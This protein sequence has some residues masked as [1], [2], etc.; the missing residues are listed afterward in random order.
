MIHPYSH[1]PRSSQPPSL[2]PSDPQ[3]LGPFSSKHVGKRQQTPALFHF[4]RQFAAI[5]TPASRS[6]SFLP[7]VP[8]CLCASSPL[9]PHHPLPHVAQRPFLPSVPVCLSAFVPRR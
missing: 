6:E 4:P 9:F 8:H 7:F 5:R 1:R 3:T 2:G